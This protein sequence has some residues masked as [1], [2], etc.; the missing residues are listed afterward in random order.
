MS[1]DKSVVILGATGYVGIVSKS[2]PHLSLCFLCFFFP[3]LASILYRQAISP[4][5]CVHSDVQ[6]SQWSFLSAPEKSP[7]F[8]FFFFFFRN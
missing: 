6:A 1:S 8:F 2:F 5:K 3:F 4:L 7:T